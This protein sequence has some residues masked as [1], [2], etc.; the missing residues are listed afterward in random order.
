MYLKLAVGLGLGVYALLSAT[1]WMMTYALLR[2][3]P[4][5]VEANPMAAACLEQYGWNGLA[6]YKAG[7]VLVFVGAVFLLARRRP[8]VAVGVVAVG[9]AVLLS[10]TVYTHGLICEAKRETADA[11]WPKPKPRPAAETGFTV[12]DRCWFATEQPVV[13]ASGTFPAPAQK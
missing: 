7:G 13:T 1:D 12:P 3:H 5:A 9:C 2:I 11:A 10:V 4:G 6:L 8:A